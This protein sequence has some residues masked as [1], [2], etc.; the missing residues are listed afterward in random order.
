[1]TRNVFHWYTVVIFLCQKTNTI[2][3]RALFIRKEETTDSSEGGGLTAAA[4]SGA[5]TYSGSAHEFVFYLLLPMMDPRMPR[6]IERPIWE[7]M[8]RTTDLIMASP[9]DCRWLPE[10]LPALAA[11]FSLSSSAA[12]S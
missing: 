4:A 11:A 7:P 12:A 9:T 5:G 1:M 6:T 8:V 2:A 3:F 10:L